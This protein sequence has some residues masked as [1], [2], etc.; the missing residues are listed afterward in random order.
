MPGPPYP[1]PRGQNRWGVKF[2]PRKHGPPFDQR[3]RGSGAFPRHRRP[4]PSFH[5]DRDSRVSPAIQSFKKHRNHRPGHSQ[6]NP[7]YGNELQSNTRPNYNQYYGEEERNLNSDG[8]TEFWNAWNSQYKK[9]PEPY[10][11]SIT[12]SNAG[13]QA[14]KPQKEVVESGPNKY[15]KMLKS[16]WTGTQGSKGS[17]QGNIAGDSSTFGYQID[18]GFPRKPSHHHGGRHR[19][20]KQVKQLF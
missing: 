4:P 5:E 20:P 13:G 16:M 15:W 7:F 19:K 1:D 8:Q 11:S 12:I 10:K 3:G 2:D 14:A 9:K 17:E 18:F 6:S